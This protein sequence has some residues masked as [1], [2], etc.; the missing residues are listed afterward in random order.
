MELIPVWDSLP[1]LSW[2]DKVC[3]LT[4]ELLGLEQ[5]ENSVK[6]L[7]EADRYIRELALP[8][9]SLMTGREHLRGHEMQLIAGSVVVIAP[10]GRFRF[11]AFASMHTKPGFHAVVYAIT[12]VVAR[13]VHAN[14][15]NLKDIDALEAQWFGNA[16]P[17]I[18]RGQAISRSLKE[19]A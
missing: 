18:A 10:D 12:D 1:E 9:G 3:L 19:L 13:T 6:H 2:K 15:S 4:H 5:M 17:I 16:D 11:D 14:P 8:A 7:F